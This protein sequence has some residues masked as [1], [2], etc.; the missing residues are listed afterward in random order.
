MTRE[1]EPLG[2][3]YERWLADRR[4]YLAELARKKNRSREEKKR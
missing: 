3:S 4:R 1:I 2:L